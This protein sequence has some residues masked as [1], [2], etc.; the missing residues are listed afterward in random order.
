M[1]NCMLPAI[2]GLILCIPAIAILT[3][4]I[5]SVGVGYRLYLLCACS[6]L[7]SLRSIHHK[8][9]AELNMI[10]CCMSILVK[11]REC[12]LHYCTTHAT[13]GKPPVLIIHGAF[14]SSVPFMKLACELNSHFTPYV[15]DMPGWGI[16]D[17]VSL[18]DLEADDIA[19]MNVETMKQ[20]M[21]ALSIDQ[22]VIVA[23]SVGGFFAIHFAAQHPSKVSQLV[24]LNP[25]GIFST[26]GDTG[27]YWAVLFKTGLHHHLLRILSYFFIPAMTCLISSQL[28]LF[29]LTLLASPMPNVALLPKFIDVKFTRSGWKKPCFEILCSLKVQTS[30][31]YGSQDS[32][33]PHHQGCF[34]GLLSKGRL[35]CLD[36]PARHAPHA[37]LSDFLIAFHDA[38][39]KG[40]V[41]CDIFD[42]QAAEASQ[43]IISTCISSFNPS[44]TRRR[45]LDMYREVARKFS[46]TE[47]VDDI[48]T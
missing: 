8:V 17:G 29:Q 27:A 6:Q 22:A 16:S 1:Q 31:I 48:V 3:I 12:K 45:V 40:A 46:I 24:L 44:E 37:L 7:P 41:P 20:F 42:K 15:I 10:Q 30:L 35:P 36:V 11:G 23:H 9:L 39:H 32:L 34:L 13:I 21:D 2:L 19:S 47:E 38:L 25:A 18:R 5:V 4:V 14:A 26:L 33:I 28:A 43:S